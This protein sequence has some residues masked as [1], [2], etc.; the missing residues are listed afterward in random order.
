MKFQNGIKA[1]RKLAI[2]L[3]RFQD[4]DTVLPIRSFGLN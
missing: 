2:I 1:G 4:K 3:R